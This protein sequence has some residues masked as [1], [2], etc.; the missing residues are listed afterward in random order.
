MNFTERLRAATELLEAIAKDRQL[1][2]E[3]S[4]AE[5]KRL[6]EAAGHVYQPDTVARR[7]LVKANRKTVD[8]LKQPRVMY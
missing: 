1:L 7:R 8:L 6:I 2:A 3:A 5:Q 4:T